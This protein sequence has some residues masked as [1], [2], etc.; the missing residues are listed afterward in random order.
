MLTDIL[1]DAALWASFRAAVVRRARPVFRSAFQIGAA[2]GAREYPVEQ[3]ERYA[4]SALGALTER[5]APEGMLADLF[6]MKA[7]IPGLGPGMVPL[8]D[9]SGL[10]ALPFDYDEIASA[11]DRVVAEYTDDWWRTVEAGTRE[12]MRAIL[13]RAASEGLTMP[14]I[15]REFEPLFGQARA[16][17][18]AVAETT[19]LLGMGAQE[20]YRRAGF[21]GWV[22]RTVRDTKVDPVC[23]QLGK[24]SDPK[25]RPPGRPFP[26]TRRFQ[27]AHIG[28]RCWPVPAGQPTAARILAANPTIPQQFRPA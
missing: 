3:K 22:W 13:Q 21:D 25:E 27:R 16:A 4:I 17:R 20:T 12:R 18:I 2:L 28:C 9:E 1:E 10:V 24:D 6:G 26:M 5:L 23:V 15:I 11:A 7:D 8:P 14:E 19:N